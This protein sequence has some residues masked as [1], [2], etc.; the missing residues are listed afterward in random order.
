MSSSKNALST[1]LVGVF[2][3]IQGWIDDDSEDTGP[4]ITGLTDSET[5]VNN[6]LNDISGDDDHD[7]SKGCTHSLFSLLTCIGSD[8]SSI[9]GSITGTVTDDTVCDQTL[10]RLFCSE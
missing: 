10:A 9:S 6:L 4:I 7:T 1:Q 2:P 5:F 8:V 3:L